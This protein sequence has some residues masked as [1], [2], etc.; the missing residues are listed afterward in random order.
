MNFP[1]AQYSKPLKVLRRKGSTFATCCSCAWPCIHTAYPC[2]NLAAYP[3]NPWIQAFALIC[4][5][6]RAERSYRHQSLHIEHIRVYK[7]E[8]FQKNH[9][10]DTEETQ[11]RHRE[12]TKETKETQR[13]HKRRCNEDPSAGMLTCF[14]ALIELA[15]LLLAP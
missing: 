7:L 13:K 5:S 2:S 11:R 8:W 4:L 9:R 3:S 10:R 1:A 14:F 6:K 12:G 15:R